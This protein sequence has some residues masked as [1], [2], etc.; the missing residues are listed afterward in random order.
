MERSQRS[1]LLDDAGRVAAERRREVLDEVDLVH[2]AS[3]DRLAN[4]LHRSSVLRR[5][6]RLLPLANREAARVRRRLVFRSDPHGAAPGSGQGSGGDGFSPRRR[7][8]DSP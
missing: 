7:A 5:R 2:V 8:F 4:R 3:C 1:E 6:P